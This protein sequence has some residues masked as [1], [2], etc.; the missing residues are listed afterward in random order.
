MADPAH[1]T[2]ILSGT[3]VG[4]GTVAYTTVGQNDYGQWAGDLHYFYEVSVPLS[5]FG[6]NW[7][8]DNTFALQWTQNCANDS[9]LIDP[10]VT[11]TVPE[12]GTLALLPLGLIGLARIRRRKSA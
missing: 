3:D 9:I 12:P 5:S 2:S 8:P 7:F 4:T 6:T 10:I 11:T 1:P